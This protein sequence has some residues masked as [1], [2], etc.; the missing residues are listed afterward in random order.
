MLI[1]VN[2]GLRGYT[3]QPSL[4]DL[5]KKCE[6][7]RRGKRLRIVVIDFHENGIQEEA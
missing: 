2:L 7:W 1:F 3:G 6:G 4:V 5:L